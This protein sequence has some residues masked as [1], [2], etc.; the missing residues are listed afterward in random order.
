MGGHGGLNILPQKRWNG[1]HLFHQSNEVFGS[2]L[3]IY[4]V[5]LAVYGRE[6]RLKVARDEEKYN[7]EQKIKQDAH[8]QVNR[9]TNTS[10]G[11]SLI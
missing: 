2:C 8:T 1:A 4:V 11:H 7:A 10:C 6:N 3:L 9:S 5:K